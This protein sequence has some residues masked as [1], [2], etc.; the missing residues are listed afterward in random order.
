MNIIILC[1]ITAAAVA[2]PSI[3]QHRDDIQQHPS[4][5][6]CGMSREKFDFSRMLIEYDDGSAVPVCSLHCAAIE[7]AQSLDKTPKAIKVGDMN[8]K[9]SIDAEAAVWVIGGSKMGVMSKRGK[10][11]FAKK[12]DADA[13]QKQNGGKIGSFEDAVKTAYEDIYDDTRMIRERRKE[14]RMKMES[15][16]H[17]QMQHGH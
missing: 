13:F 7:L 3:A 8:T 10:W 14:K 2:V 1:F 9:Q 6:Y 4:C 11:A 17:G 15:P 12:E 16:G 5:K